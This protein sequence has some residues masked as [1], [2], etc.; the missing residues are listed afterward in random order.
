MITKKGLLTTPV[1]FI[2][3][4]RPE[5]TQMV[6][7]EI[8]KARPKELFVSA[9]GP[10]Q[11]KPADIECCRV[12]RDIVKKVDWDCQVHYNFN[13]KNLGCKIAVSSAINWFFDNVEAG[14]ILEDDC[15]PNQSFFW[16][17]QELLKKYK[18]DARIMQISGNNYLFGKRIGE[19]TYYFS[20]INDI[21]GWASWRR[22]WKHYD[23]NMKGFPEFRE[24]GQIYN[25]ISNKRIARWL[26]DYFREVFE[27]AGLNH[28]I[29]SS[30]WSYAICKNN[31]LVIVPNVNLVSHI[32]IDK[33]AT[34]WKDLFISN[35]ERQEIND[36]IVP[37]F[38]L[39]DDKADVLRFKIIYKTDPRLNL[40]KT[41]QLKN[42]IKGSLKRLPICCFIS[43]YLK[44]TIK[45]LKKT[46]P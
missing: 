11:E 10:R 33:E 14:I 35:I 38:I 13:D 42:F 32:G 40:K 43:Y 21:S 22:A 17:C 12:A 31:G 34:N 7:D 1:L 20:K 9:D 19:A 36:I 39:A 23:I 25:Y 26:M 6:F 4:N 45:C 16:F 2:I 41:A 30:Q 27:L 37:E 8:R 46:N 29:W 18:D 15:L 3:F 28:G 24:Q 44:K 5:P